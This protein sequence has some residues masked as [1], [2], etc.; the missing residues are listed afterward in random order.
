MR[1][2]GQRTRVNFS[3]RC[4]DIMNRLGVRGGTSQWTWDAEPVRSAL[5]VLCLGDLQLPGQA[6]V[7]LTPYKRVVGI[8][9]S[10]KMVD[11]AITPERC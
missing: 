2:L 6:T 1:R 5:I 8:D 3:T 9:P 11:Q 10:E 7:E 4:S